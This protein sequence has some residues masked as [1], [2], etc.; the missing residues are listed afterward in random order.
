METE[1]KNSLVDKY[2]HKGVKISII[3]P[4]FKIGVSGSRMVRVDDPRDIKFL[5]DNSEKV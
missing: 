3:N 1:E 2:F 4:F 5:E